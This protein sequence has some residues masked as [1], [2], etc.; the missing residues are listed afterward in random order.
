[1]DESKG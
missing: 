1:S